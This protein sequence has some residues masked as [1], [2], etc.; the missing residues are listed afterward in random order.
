M[1]DMAYHFGVFMGDGFVE[2]YKP[3]SSVCYIGLKAIDKDFVEHYQQV[4][5]RLTGKLY[6]LHAESPESANRHT[7]WRCRVGYRELVEKTLSDTQRKLKIPDWIMMGDSEEKRAFIQ[8]V[9][10]SEAWISCTLQAL[11]PSRVQMS[12]GVT[13]DWIHSL[14]KLFSELNVETTKVYTRKFKDSPKY[15]KPRRDFYSFDIDIVQY[16]DAGLTFNILRK[17]HRLE[18]C[19]RILRDFTRDYPRYK[20]YFE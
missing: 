4:L 19:S 2:R 7:R 14:H 8:G 3:G 17:R 20:T 16:V 5:F 12:V 9:M 11:G 10:D 1:S 13:S 6:K 15:L 18:Y